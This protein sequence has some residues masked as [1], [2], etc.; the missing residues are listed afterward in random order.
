MYIYKGIEF[1]SPDKLVKYICN[2]EGIT[3]SFKYI[4]HKYGKGY[5]KRFEVKKPKRKVIE[6]PCSD[7]DKYKNKNVKFHY[8][9][10]VCNKDVYTT[11]YIIDHFKDNLCKRCRKSNQKLNQH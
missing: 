8:K 6:Y 10:K 11:W 9:C 2:E 1:N 7:F 3:P 5:L 4:Y